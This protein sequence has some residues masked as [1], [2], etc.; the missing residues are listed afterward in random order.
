MSVG[1][2]RILQR[3]RE[4]GLEPHLQVTDADT[5]AARTGL[6]PAGQGLQETRR[7]GGVFSC[8]DRT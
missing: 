4:T 3:Q 7:L 5:T 2:H 1:P 6:T 8:H